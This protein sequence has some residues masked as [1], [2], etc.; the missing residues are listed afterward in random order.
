MALRQA[1][2]E[3][4]VFLRNPASAVFTLAFPLMF[5]VVFASL[6]HG[7]R[8][9]TLGGLPYD[10]FYVPGIVAYG[11]ASTCYA[12]LAVTL[13]FRRQAGILRRLRA[14]PLP[15]W[16]ALAGIAGAAVLVGVVLAVVTSAVGVVGYGVRFPG[17]WAA[18]AVDVGVGALCFCGI[19]AAV[20][21]LVPDA[22]AAPPIVN[23]V[24]FLL[25]F[26]SGTFFPVPAG[27]VLATI[28]R[29]FPIRP[30]NRALF[31]AFDPRIAPGWAHG[32]AWR[33]LGV[34]VAWGVAGTA[35][36]VWRWRWEPR[37]R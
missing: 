35:V 6:E 34:V 31:A 14:S 23:V 24:F 28:S 13:C 11:L 33:Q 2:Y 26:T 36:A 8:V 18:A 20:S 12:N 29:V 16:A 10:Q 4:L 22:D 15:A 27:S 5:L 30:L 3:L 37:R 1:G 9:A 32:F 25:L 21:T 17:H 7:Q 19:G